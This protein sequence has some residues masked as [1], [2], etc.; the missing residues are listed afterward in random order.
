MH[1]ELGYDGNKH[2]SHFAG[3]THEK[4]L[5]WSPAENDRPLARTLRRHLLN[6]PENEPGREG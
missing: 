5:E 3:C 1:E 2:L 6:G 4:H